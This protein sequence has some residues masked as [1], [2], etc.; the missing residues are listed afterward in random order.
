MGSVEDYDKKKAS[1]EKAIAEGIS[2]GCSGC[3]W[4]IIIL[5]LTAL[6]ITWMVTR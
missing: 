2:Q 6:A 5:C 1:E 3:I 4:A